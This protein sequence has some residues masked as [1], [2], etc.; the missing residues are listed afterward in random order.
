[1]KTLEHIFQMFLMKEMF[2]YI[3]FLQIFQSPKFTKPNY[4][5]VHNFLGWSIFSNLFFVILNIQGK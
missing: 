2:I 3:F 4:F 5:R 1:M